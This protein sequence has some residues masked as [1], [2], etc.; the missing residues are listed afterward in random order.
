MPAR[1]AICPR[2]IR[3]I[4]KFVNPMFAGLEKS[5]KKTGKEDK[6]STVIHARFSF[7]E[8][9][10]FSDIKSANEKHSPFYHF[11]NADAIKIFIP[12]EIRIAYKEFPC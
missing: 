9:I 7:M 8:I 5:H 12:E 10:V 1:P 3:T 4:G 6:K 11:L 2:L